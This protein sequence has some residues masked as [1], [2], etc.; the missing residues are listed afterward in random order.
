MTTP[1]NGQ[2]ITK[3]SQWL[4]KLRQRFWKGQSSAEIYDS[5]QKLLFAKFYAESNN[6]PFHL[7]NFDTIYTAAR[8]DYEVRT[9]IDMGPLPRAVTDNP[10]DYDEAI[11]MIGE[12]QISSDPNIWHVINNLWTSKSMRKEDGQYFTPYAIKLFMCMVYR[13]TPKS[14]ICD[15]C[16]GSGG[17]LIMAANLLRSID[18]NLFY[19]ND[20]DRKQI[21][22]VAQL[23]FATYRRRRTGQD[24]AHIH[25]S[26]NDA[27]DGPWPNTMDRIYT[28]VPFGQKVS[29]LRILD[30]YEVGRSKASE[31]TQLLF[32]EKCIKQLEPNGLFATVVDKG[33][34]TNQK[35]E[36]ERAKLAE[37]AALELVVELPGVAFEHFAGTTFP[38]YLLFFRKGE[39]ALT[40]YEKVSDIGYDANG[41]NIRDVGEG[42]CDPFDSCLELENYKN[43]DL[44]E[45][46]RR[47]RNRNWPENS[48]P[49]HDYAYDTTLTGN[50]M[51][52][53]WKR[54]GGQS[55]QLNDI[56]TMLKDPWDGRNTRN[57]TVDRN[58]R[59]VKD[60]HLI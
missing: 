22:K 38:T 10:D 36:R 32:I 55:R 29:A 60:T 42:P 20:S 43:C 15:P 50:W 23:A 57:P 37:M 14:K 58:F 45:I 11:Q 53:S 27:L 40:R 41:Y 8:A 39:P 12:T 30:Q 28:N 47:W 49:E 26:T 48:D 33:I 31:L 59:L 7:S 44:H 34:V 24:L 21:A 9:G 25:C 16:G 19:Y 52:G 54:Q 2:R 5:L 6:R 4:K 17:F 13:P 46:E 1:A 35:H 18:P 51:W 3:T 56:A